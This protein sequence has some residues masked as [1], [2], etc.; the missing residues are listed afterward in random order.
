MWYRIRSRKLPDLWISEIP[1]Q[2]FSALQS[3]AAQHGLPIEEYAK[4]VLCDTVALASIEAEADISIQQLVDNFDAYLR[5][6]ERQTVLFSD[7]RGRRF[8][9]MPATKFERIVSLIGDGD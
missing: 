1:D 3:L 6:A 9:L 2:A 8:A 5:L 7:E 4:Q